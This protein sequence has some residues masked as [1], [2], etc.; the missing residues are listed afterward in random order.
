MIAIVDYGMG[1][2]GSI[3]N[4]FR[5]VGAQAVVTAD[6]AVIDRAEKLV[7][8]GVGAF[9]HGMRNLAE[10]GLVEVLNRKAMQER[11]PVL[12]VCLGMQLLTEHSEEGTLPGLGWIPGR[13]VRFDRSAH[14]GLHV[15]HMGWNTL[16]WRADHPL[17]AELPPNPRFYFVHA[18]HVICRHDYHLLA[19]TTYGYPFASAIADGNVVG[20]QFHPEKSH[21]FGMAVFHAFAALGVGQA[22]ETPVGAGAA[23]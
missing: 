21:R 9:D 18:Y 10:R 6:P 1:N 5:K 13:T 20:M 17:L 22:A 23:G 14:P 19:H 15:M 3:Q 4:M 2:L 11:V 16:D 7:L 12:G 8:P